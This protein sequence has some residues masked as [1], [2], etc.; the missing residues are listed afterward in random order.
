[1]LFE[2]IDKLIHLAVRQVEQ[3]H[4]NLFRNIAISVLE[5]CQ[6][7]GGR[8]RCFIGFKITGFLYQLIKRLFRVEPDMGVIQQTDRAVIKLIL[9]QPKNN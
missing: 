4:T 2:F 3:E 7:R 1:M 8:K 5:L 6:I 9:H